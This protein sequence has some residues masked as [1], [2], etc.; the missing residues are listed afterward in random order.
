MLVCMVPHMILCGHRHFVLAILGDSG[1][2]PLK[3]QHA[4]DEYG[5]ESTH[6]G[7]MPDKP[8]K[9]LGVC[10]VGIQ[11]RPV[12]RSNRNPLATTIRLAPASANTA[13]SGIVPMHYSR[14]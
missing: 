14:A 6:S 12:P 13:N 10:V 8:C 3:R 4:K 11:A 5:N 1:I 7:I 9:K 2:A